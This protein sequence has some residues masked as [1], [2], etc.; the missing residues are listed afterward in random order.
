MRDMIVL[1]SESPSQFSSPS[2]WH[3]IATLPVSLRPS[4][5]VFVTLPKARSTGTT[6]STAIIRYSSYGRK[7]MMN[8][9]RRVHLARHQLSLP[10]R[11]LSPPLFHRPLQLL[12]Q[13]FVNPMHSVIVLQWKSQVQHIGMARQLHL[14]ILQVPLRFSRVIRTRFPVISLT[15]SV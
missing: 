4:H 2:I 5:S 12:S 6:T 14:L 13:N 1:Y 11:L 7:R 3:V 15:L 8:K 9:V 10:I